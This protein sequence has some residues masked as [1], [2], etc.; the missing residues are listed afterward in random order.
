M[1]DSKSTIRKVKAQTELRWARKS[2]N[3]MK[4][5]FVRSKYKVKEVTGP[6]LGEN[7][8][9]LMKDRGEVERS[10]ASFALSY[11]LKKRTGSFRNETC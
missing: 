8:E 5:S 1:L 9:N 11:S 4:G 2:C 3:Y 10:S 6:L 7:G